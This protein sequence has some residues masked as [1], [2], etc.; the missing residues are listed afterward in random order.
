MT[1]IPTTEVS[2]GMAQWYVPAGMGLIAVLIL[3]GMV[4]A[5]RINTQRLILGTRLDES[6]KIQ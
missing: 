4:T 6:S 3:G 2:T 1:V 5:Y